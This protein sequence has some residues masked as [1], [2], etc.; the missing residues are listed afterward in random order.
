MNTLASILAVGSTLVVLGCASTAPQSLTGFPFEMDGDTY[1][2]VA[3]PGR[4]ESANDLLRRE[5]GRVALRARDFDQDGSLDT[6]LVGS[7]SLSEANAIYVHGIEQAR[8]RGLYR[9]REPPRMYVLPHE[10]GWLVV[11]SVASSG[12]SWSNRFVRYAP[13]GQIEEVY[14]DVDADGHLDDDENILVVPQQDYETVLKAARRD[15][16]IETIGSRVRVRT[17]PTSDCQ[18]R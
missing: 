8:A 2:I 13:D 18:P 14:L 4:P 17:S 1:V 10:G 9:V 16:R 3:A 6:L 11:V 7:L 15:G 12:S 5:D